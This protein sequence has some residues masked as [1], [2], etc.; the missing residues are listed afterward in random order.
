MSKEKDKKQSEFKKL[1]K[2]MGKC[3]VTGREV[4]EEKKVRGLR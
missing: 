1:L 4:Y 2:N 3:V